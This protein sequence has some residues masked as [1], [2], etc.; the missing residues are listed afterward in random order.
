[1][2]KTL[3][4]VGVLLILAVLFFPR[5]FILHVHDKK[6]AAIAAET[7]VPTVKV[8]KMHPRMQ[9]IR[10]VLP[11]YL[12]AINTT[13]IWARVNGYLSNF[14]VDLGDKVTQ[15]DLLAVI[16]APDVDAALKRAEGELASMIAK[17]EIAKITA[18]RWTHLY[19][20]NPESV[21][22]EEVDVKIADYE[23]AVANVEA[24]IGNVDYWKA[25]QGFENIYA[26]FNGIITS[27]TVDIGSLITLGS[28]ND[29]SEFFMYTQKQELFQIARTDTLRAFVDVP[30]SLFYLVKDG[31]EV[32]VTIW[33]YPEQ[34]FH[35]IINRNTQ[36]LN[37]KTR[38]LLTQVNIDNSAGKLMPGLYA[39]VKLEFQPQKKTFTI[40]VGALVVRNGPTYVC[41][42]KNN[43][44]HYQEVKIGVDDGKTLQI[45]DG[46]KPNDT[47]LIT[48]TAQILDGMKVSPIYISEEEERMLL[49]P[50]TEVQGD[51]A[52]MG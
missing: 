48:P 28:E 11:S 46:L 4:I 33:Q 8:L 40:P 24:A 41:V 30:Q 10:I 9:P 20:F 2:K 3:L 37:P 16:S 31:L 29:P 5:F 12:D 26:P 38:T 6:I 45:I 36:S 18:D 43:I 50:P 35:G 42:V 1:M 51:S 49:G 32:E 52:I 21:S 7:N 34:K 15:G 44:V 17:Q 47:I 25:M 22:R 13:P 39:E 19:E 14:L 23:A 27:R